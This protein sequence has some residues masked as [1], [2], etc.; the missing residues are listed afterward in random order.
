[1]DVLFNYLNKFLKLVIYVFILIDGIR[2]S[3]LDPW[4]F[5]PCGISITDFSPFTFQQSDVVHRLIESV[6]IKQQRPSSV[7]IENCKTEELYRKDIAPTIFRSMTYTC[8]VHIHINPGKNLHS[9]LPLLR[10]MSEYHHNHNNDEE[11]TQAVYKK[12][13]FIILVNN[14]PRTK[15]NKGGWYI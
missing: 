15:Y 10:H 5:N 2:C 3:L 1:M 8:F 4:S 11:N 14:D 6:Q 12:A 9:T 13:L 7:I